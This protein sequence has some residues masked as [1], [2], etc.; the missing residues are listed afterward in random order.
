MEPQRKKFCVDYQQAREVPGRPMCRFPKWTC[1]FGSHA[2]RNCGKSGHGADD[3]KSAI[4]NWEET[5]EPKSAPTPCPP[6]LQEPPASTAHA[7]IPAPAVQRTAPNPTPEA[8][9]ETAVF[10]RGFGFKGEGK[11]S[12]YGTSIDPPSVVAPADLPPALQGP[13]SSSSQAAAP[14]IPDVPPPIAATTEDVEEWVATNFKPLK[15]LSTKCPP[16]IGENILWRGLKTGRGG[17]PSTKVEHFN[18]KVRYMQMEG[19]GELYL[20]L[21]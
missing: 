4:T 11:S 8:P 3:C 2:C 5:T 21:D 1:P 7:P 10:V 6:T 17:N 14:P 19:D 20:Y 16:E 15:N 13:S 9:V 18:G 12:N